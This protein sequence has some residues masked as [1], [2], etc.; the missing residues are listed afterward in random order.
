MYILLCFLHVHTRL[1][2]AVK[3]S[4]LDVYLSPFGLLKQKHPK[5]AYKRQV[6][7]S[8]RSGGYEVQDADLSRFGV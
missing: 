2:L 8:K 3:L 4:K 1:A 6:F 5:L 7:I